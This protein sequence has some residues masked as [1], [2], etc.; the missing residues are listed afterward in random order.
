[1][2]DNRNRLMNKHGQFY[3]IA[4]IFTQFYFFGGF[5]YAM[6][7]SLSLENGDSGPF[8]SGFMHFI[9]HF[10]LTKQQ[11]S[12]SLHSLLS[13]QLT[14]YPLVQPTNVS[15][16]QPVPVTLLPEIKYKILMI[17]QKTKY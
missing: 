15:R 4:F 9:S 6:Q 3:N 1:M 12:P 10:E 16:G 17:I 8:S 5:A 7:V 14:S 13:Q 11:I 2:H